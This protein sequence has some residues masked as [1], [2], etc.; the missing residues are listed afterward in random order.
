MLNGDMLNEICTPLKELMENFAD[1]V[2]ERVI[3]KMKAE[4]ADKPKYYIFVDKCKNKIYYG[5]NKE[6][7]RNTR[8]LYRE[9][10]AATCRSSYSRVV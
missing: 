4:D 9:M 10:Y 5:K 6:N 8:I 2:A 1:T 3:A 7:S